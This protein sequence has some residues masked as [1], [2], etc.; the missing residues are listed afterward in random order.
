MIGRIW[1][2]IERTQHSRLFKIIASCVIVAVALAMLIIYSVASAKARTQ[3]IEQFRT[4]FGDAAVQEVLNNQASNDQASGDAATNAN[5]ASSPRA[6]SQAQDGDSDEA[7]RAGQEVDE[8]ARVIRSIIAAQYN[9]SSIAI[10]IG[11]GTLLCLTVIWVS[12]GLTYLLLAVG[13]ALMLGIA[14]LSGSLKSLAPFI[15]GIFALTGSFSALMRLMMVALSWSSPVFS[16]ARNV[17]QE[18]IRMKVSLIFIVAMI[19]GLAVLP[20]L[21]SDDQPLRYRIQSFLQYGTSG[22]F[23]LIAILIV[24]FSVMTVASE[25]RDKQIW[26]TVTKPVAAWQYVLGKWLGMAALSAS[27]LGVSAS[28]IFVFTEYLRHQPAQGET[29]AFRAS[30]GAMLTEDRFMVETQVLSSRRTIAPDPAPWNPKQLNEEIEK[31]IQVELDSMQVPGDTPEQLAANKDA[32][33]ERIRSDLLKGLSMSYRTIL[34]ADNRIYTFS[35]LSDAKNSDRPL[36]FRYKIQ[37]GSNMPDQ[38]YK[39]TIAFPGVGQ[40]KVEDVPLDQIKVLELN[41]GLINERGEVIMQIFNGDAST[42]TPNP[43]AFTFP[44]EGLKLSYASSSYQANYMRLMFVLW[45]KLLFLA[46]VG[47]CAATFLS[48]PVAAIVS[49][50]IFW[51]A[52]GAKSLASALETYETTTLQGQTIWFNTAVAKIAELISSIFSVYSNLRPTGRLVEGEYL[53]WGSLASGTIVVSIWCLVL[54]AAGVLI[55]RRRELAIYSGH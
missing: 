26:Q 33:R 38:L 20:M 32:A 31:K 4:E 17:L 44:S 7:R 50:A 40:A 11:L 6:M 12:M 37:S 18:A 22:T 2:I 35:G 16:I 49:F 42:Q 25:Q 21:L 46:M 8:G 54:F 47:V 19:F 41:A 28:G 10:A 30:Q 48:F 3:M 52:E 24:L 1:S 23:G 55:F 5:S 39:V 51:A 45:I 9:T 36:I 15:V 43:R 34:P 29:S 13:C 14:A 27:L 53:G